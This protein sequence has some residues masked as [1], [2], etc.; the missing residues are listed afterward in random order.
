MRLGNG[1]P[2]EV[3]LLKECVIYF[4]SPFVGENVFI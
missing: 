2:A 4:A 3:Q 1:Y